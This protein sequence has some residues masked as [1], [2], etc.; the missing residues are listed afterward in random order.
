MV[1]AWVSSKVVVSRI[2]RNIKGV[3]ADYLDSIPEWIAEG[4]RKLKTK[5]SLEIRHKDI[6]VDFHLGA[7]N[8]PAES[9]ICV[10]FRGTKLKYNPD[11]MSHREFNRDRNSNLFLENLF[12]SDVPVY[13]T[14]GDP[15]QSLDDYTGGNPFPRDIIQRL[16]DM[17]WHQHEWWYLN[18]NRIQ[19]SV[20]VCKIRLWYMTIP[21]DEQNFPLIPDVENYHEALYWYNRMKLIEAGFEDKV[22]N[23]QM[24]MHLWNDY[25]GKAIADITYPTPEQVEEQVY[26][27]LNLFPHEYHWGSHVDW[28][29]GGRALL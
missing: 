14:A 25:A 20:P 26:R 6:S 10:E 7:L 28:D 8:V 9:I 4:V 1:T 16:V 21:M 18:G 19:V 23:H 5:Y 24:A 17:P 29:W 27:H 12:F 3:E 13:S 22:T 11:G 15:I 2:F